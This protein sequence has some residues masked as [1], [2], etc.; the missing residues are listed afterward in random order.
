VTDAELAGFDQLSGLPTSPYA[1]VDF[2]NEQSYGGG[3]VPHPGDTGFFTAS[4]ADLIATSK[5]QMR[6]ERKLR[7][8]G[9]KVFLAIVLVLVVALGVG[10][11]AYTQG[12]G[13]PSQEAVVTDF[14][15]AYAAGESVEGY[16]VEAGDEDS[17]TLER[18]LDGVAKSSDVSV[19]SIEAKM[20]ESQVLVDVRLAGSEAAPL[21]YRIDLARDFIGWKISGIEL[22]FASTETAG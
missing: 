14:F 16:W 11:A 17:Q 21:H 1:P 15:K 10:I 9:L 8:T 6:K 4:D 3:N 7:H 13:I 18:L 12:I 5:R 2:D 20:R 19:W 22:V